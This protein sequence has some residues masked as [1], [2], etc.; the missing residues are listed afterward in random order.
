VRALGLTLIDR[1]PA[2]WVLYA[3]LSAD[4]AARSD[5]RDALAWVNRTLFLRP[6]DARVHVA[7]ARALLRLDR[8]SQALAELKIAWA[9]GDPSTLE[10]GLALAEKEGDWSRVLIDLPGHLERLWQVMLRRGRPADARAL[11]QAA[12]DFP[13]SEAVRAE[14][15][16]LLVRHDA[17]RGDPSVALADLD[18]LPAEV[19][20][21]VELAMTRAQL[22]VKLGRGDEAVG[23]LERLL[24]REPQNLTVG[25]AL[26]DLFASLGRPVEARAVLQRV[27][28]FAG[29]PPLRSALFQR[30]AG[31]W[32]LE[33]RYP[34][35]LE[36]IQTASRIEP[37][38]ADL[39]Y[40]T[41]EVFERMGSLHSALDE[42]QKGRALD[43]PEGARAHEAQIKRLEAALGPTPF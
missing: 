30:E 1:H 41:A 16:L 23:E 40:R 27:R 18:R 34:R 7:A 15:A 11:L 9:L 20:A 2:D 43:T 39:H 4:T 24:N 35:A 19:R 38:R 14:A 6:N 21:R 8:R 28:P 31:L 3:N 26:T 25:F 37:G 32:L 42:F 17:E 29:T 36:A 13:P 12:V 33:E 5:P 22:L 10:L